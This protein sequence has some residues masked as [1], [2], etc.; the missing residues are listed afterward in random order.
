MLTMDRICELKNK[1]SLL[2]EELNRIVC[3]GPMC[4]GRILELSEQLDI[5]IT[6]YY[7]IKNLEH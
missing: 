1:I 6:D 3:T 2:K 7:S 5:L 4:S